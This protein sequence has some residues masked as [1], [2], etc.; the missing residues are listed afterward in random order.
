[1]FYDIQVDAAEEGI[2]T[3]EC[4][5]KEELFAELEK[6]YA[7]GERKLSVSSNDPSLTLDEV[8]KYD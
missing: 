8:F 4:D 1:M 6:L 2:Y 5:S 3:I 7:K